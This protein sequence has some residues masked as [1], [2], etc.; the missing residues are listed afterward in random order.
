MAASVCWGVG[1]KG[2]LI[3]EVGVGAIVEFGAWLVY[4]LYRLDYGF[5]DV[6]D[7]SAFRTYTQYCILKL[8]DIHANAY[9]AFGVGQDT[10]EGVLLKFNEYIELTIDKNKDNIEAS[11]QRNQLAANVISRRDDLLSHTP[12]SKGILL[13]L[14]TRHGTWDHLDINNRGKL[15]LD[16]YQD[17]KE[18]VTWVLKS[19]QTRAEWHK[20]LCRMTKDGFSL[21][22]GKNKSVVVAQQEQQLV[23]FL[24]EGIN[25]DAD[26]YKAKKE[27]TMVYDR[28]KSDIAWGY[29]LAM[30][31]SVYYQLNSLSN[32][33]YPKRCDFGPCEVGLD[34]LA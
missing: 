22:T 24:Q 19:I 15:M 17:R 30:N 13:Y 32:P 21:A 23:N 18:A 10:I 8:S 16:I 11:R 7:Q 27:L 31:D 4:Q 1:A 26:L 29:A 9:E 2:G 5:F 25:R 6:V 28:L 14:L 12:E 34:H 20:V 3:G 33:H